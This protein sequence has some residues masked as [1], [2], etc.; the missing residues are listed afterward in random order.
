MDSVE[1]TFSVLELSMHGISCQKVLLPQHQSTFSK[2]VMIDLFASHQKMTT[3]EPLKKRASH[4][5]N[6]LRRS[7]SDDDDDDK[8]VIIIVNIYDITFI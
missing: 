6:C 2:D 7:A 4:G 1:L 8:S 3:I 5:H